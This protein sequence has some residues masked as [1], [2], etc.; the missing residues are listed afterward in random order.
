VILGIGAVLFVSRAEAQVTV[1][2]GGNS[3][4][5]LSTAL[6]QLSVPYV[7]ANGESTP[8]PASYDVGLGDIILISNDGGGGPYFDYTD[9]LNSGG[10]LIVVGGS[11]VNEYRTWA[12]LY[13][14]TTDTSLGWH[15]DGAWYNL[16][17]ENG[18]PL[19]YTFEDSGATYHML[20]FDVTP[21]TYYYGMNDE[22]QLIAAV[23]FFDNGG[24]LN[25]MALDIGT[26]GTGNDLNNFVLPWLSASLTPL[27]FIP[28]P[29]TYLL[30]ATG[31]S[32]LWAGHRRRRATSARVDRDAR[33]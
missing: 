31:L 6:D 16:Y 2:L 9:F 5:I 12:S 4:S 32:A 29:S 3:T 13:F 8:D 17:A 25:Y 18:L 15:T 27:V 14:N 21:N 1:L 11:N 22:G 26:Y 30:L 10:Q 7:L 23:R 33:A 19:N 24:S 28:E 20:A